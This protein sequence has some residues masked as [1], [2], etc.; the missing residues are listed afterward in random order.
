[1]METMVITN[2]SERL[3]EVIKS[4]QSRIKA[5]IAKKVPFTEVDDIF[6]EIVYN[7]IKT[8][9]LSGPID[10]VAAWLF[11]AAR[12]EVIDRYRKKRETL[13]EDD[14]DGALSPELLEISDIISLEP[15][16]AEDAYLRGLFWDELEA[17]LERL[18]PE[19]RD[20]FVKTEL[21]GLSFKEVATETSLPINTL[22]SRKHKAVLA[23]RKDLMELYDLIV[24]R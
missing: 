13:F 4:C 15:E 22:L 8:E 18:T 23:L 1:M 24:N 16:S 17:A 10:L 2:N 5:F 20:I 21:M 9:A 11:K 14:N 6:Q 12:N 7:L 3:L 19:Q